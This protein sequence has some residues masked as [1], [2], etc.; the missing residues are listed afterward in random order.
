[1]LPNDCAGVPGGPAQPG[2]ACDDNDAATGNDTWNA[3]CQCVGEVLDCEGTPGGTSQPGSACDDGDPCTTGDEWDVNCNCAGLFADSDSDG[4]CDA[5][6]VCAGSPEPGQSCDDNNPCTVNDVVDANCNC[7]GTF[8]DDDGDG[9]CDADDACPGSPEPGQAC[10][11]NN[12]LTINDVVDA[13]CTCAG[14]PIGNCTELLT[15]EIA[16]DNNGSQTTWE[17]RDASGTTVILSGGPYQNGLGGTTVT[18]TLCLNQLC[19]RLIVN[20]AGGNGISGGG[21][22][23]RDANNRR[24]VD[25]NG[26]FTSTSSASNEFC[27]QLSNARLINASCD[28]TRPY[29]S[30][31]QIYASFVPG[32]SGYQFWIFDPHGSYSR[33]V[34]RSTQNFAPSTLLTN[35]VPAN[36]DLNVRVRALIGGTYTEFGAA[37]RLRLTT[38]GSN[39]EAG[40]DPMLGDAAGNV[41][42]SLFPNP[43]R[44]EVVNLA[45]DGI[46]ADER[47]DIDVMDGFGKRVSAAQIA[48]PG[49]SFVHTMDL[50]TLAPGMYMVTVRVGGQQH[51]QRLVRQ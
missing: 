39:P 36:L 4:T 13:N 10:N 47:M 37:C 45:F 21:Y 8:A 49:G 22:V 17:V 41:S 48:S 29:V 32:A 46:A 1:V 38:S 42:M 14:T 3:N 12:P 31:S 50:G 6:D 27:L 7:A 18:E 16:L 9:T 51:T 33:R 26:L 43:N 2:T 40:R 24:I 25:A 30:S 23:L 34:F 44:G 15:L 11:D 5:N 35:P 19:Y 20:D 28:R